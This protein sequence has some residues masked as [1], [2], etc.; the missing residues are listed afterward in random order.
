MKKTILRL[1]LV[2]L[3]I[4]MSAI[5]TLYASN[6]DT[7]VE[8]EN[9]VAQVDLQ[10]DMQKNLD[11]NEAVG[12]EYV[13]NM[14]NHIF[15]QSRGEPSTTL[16][17]AIAEMQHGLVSIDGAGYKIVVANDT[18]T[19]LLS[20]GHLHTFSILHL[21]IMLGALVVLIF[22]TISMKK[23]Q[24]RIFELEKNAKIRVLKA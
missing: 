9:V 17:V 6:D 21:L 5:S 20:V 3:S 10:E 22:Y 23:R 1:V 15:E 12:I 4:S 8:M 13:A 24:R 16:N 2:V 18:E 19:P 14:R 7:S 11:A